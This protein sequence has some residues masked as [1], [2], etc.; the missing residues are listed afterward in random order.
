MSRRRICVYIGGR[1]NYSS[2]KSILKNISQDYRLELQVLVGAAAVVDRYGDLARTIE[3][4]G[5]PVSHKFF[6]LVE[7]ETPL[8]MTKSAGLG[9]IE[10]ATALD[11]LKPD[12]VL[13]V[14]D[15]YDVLPVA[16]ASAFMNVPLVHTMGGEVTGT[17]DESIRHAI[18]KLAH[19]HFA[20][21]EDAKK[22][23]IKMG[24]VPETVFNVGCPRNDLVLETVAKEDSDEVL[25]E[26]FSV[27]RGVGPDLDLTGDFLLVSQHPVTTEY[28]N[29]L[30]NMRTTLAAL[31]RFRMPTVLLWPNSDAGA[32]EVSRAIRSFREVNRP[33]WLHVFKDLPAETYIHL[34]NRT[35]CLIGNS[36]SGLREG[37][38][39]GTPVVNI[40]SRQSSRLVGKN[41]MSVRNDEAEIE[42]AIKEQLRRGRYEM[43]T[44]YGDGSAGSKIADTLAQFIPVIQKKINY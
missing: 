19:I 41:V 28:G 31:G 38:L 18:T 29:N 22:R 17:I 32:D 27:N 40:G 2:A 24:E 1:A 8:T 13:V 5:F 15:R 23:I 44:I 36:S 4:D 11:N 10:A 21:N 14:G 16:I 26:L 42:S 12:F 34:L 25:Q 33:D 3:D 37:A 7:G 30:S 39:L 9:M 6:S 35:A 43:D 20:A